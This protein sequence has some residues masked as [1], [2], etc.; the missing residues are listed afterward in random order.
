MRTA[1]LTVGH[2]P[3]DGVTW[4]ETYKE[5]DGSTRGLRPEHTDVEKWAREIIDYFNR[6]ITNPARERS[7]HNGRLPAQEHR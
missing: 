1:T 5:N 4:P 2:D 3:D 6:T 7:N